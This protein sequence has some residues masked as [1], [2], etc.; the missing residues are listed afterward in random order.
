[1]TEVDEIEY[2]EFVPVSLIRELQEEIQRRTQKS[3]EAVSF[4]GVSGISRNKKH[5][6]DVILQSLSRNLFLF[7]N[8]V[9]QT[10]FS[11][12]RHFN[13]ERKATDLRCE[14]NVQKLADEFLQIVEEEKYLR[15]ERMRLEG[16]I[17]AEMFA[18]AQYERLLQHEG[19]VAAVAESTDMLQRLSA[20]A[21]RMCQDFVERRLQRDN[22]DSEAVEFKGIKCEMYKKERDEL[23]QRASADMLLFY[24][25][26]ISGSP[27][28]HP[29]NYTAACEAFLQ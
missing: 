3:I 13:I 1:M 18:L 8:F 24:I 21:E 28:E 11:F 25:R 4:R 20:E 27:P 9:L 10:I 22:G 17:E 5:A 19:N 29:A 14:V 2:F 16:E 23:Y 12:P 26:Q 7:Q 6:L 15:G